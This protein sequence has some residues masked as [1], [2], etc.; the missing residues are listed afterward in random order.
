MQ[1]IEGNQQPTTDVTDQYYLI[2]GS[3]LVLSQQSERVLGFIKKPK[4][5]FNL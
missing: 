3:I 2:A 4:T 1:P 5:L